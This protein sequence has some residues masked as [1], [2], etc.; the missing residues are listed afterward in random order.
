MLPSHLS[1]ANLSLLDHHILDTQ[2]PVLELPYAL[3]K[4]EQKNQT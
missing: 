1:S 4:E 3:K 2:S